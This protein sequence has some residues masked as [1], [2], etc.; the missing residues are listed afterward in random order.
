MGV[1]QCPKGRTAKGFSR[2]IYVNDSSQ[3]SWSG[4]WHFEGGTG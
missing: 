1:E 2:E 3:Q 4:E